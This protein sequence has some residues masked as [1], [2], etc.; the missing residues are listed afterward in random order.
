MGH[1]VGPSAL[2]SPIPRRRHLGK[3]DTAARA[4]LETL[5]TAG[6]LETRAAAARALGQIAA[7]ASLPALDAAL[8]DR[9][10]QVRAQAAH[11]LGALGE[12]ALSSVPTLAA[13]ARDLSWWVRRHAAYALGRMGLTGQQA[14]ATIA[15]HDQD[16]Y[17]RDAAQE[18]LQMIDWERESPGG[19]ARVE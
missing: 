15:A 16:P 2:G 10:W 4:R 7:A 9:A 14:L 12:A 13:R 11:A 6:A 18:V 17:A 8:R 5:L 19:Q 1:R 3:A